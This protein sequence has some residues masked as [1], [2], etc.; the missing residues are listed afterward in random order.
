MSAPETAALDYDAEVQRVRRGSDPADTERNWRKLHVRGIYEEA[1]ESV[2]LLR[3]A[4]R[5]GDPIDSEK[6]CLELGDKLCYLV[7]A[8]QDRGS[9]FAE[10]WRTLLEL[11]VQPSA[12]ADDTC[13]DDLFGAVGGVASRFADER[14]GIDV[15]Q[16]MLY[17]LERCLWRLV[18]VAAYYGFTVED[19]Q[20]AN[21]AKLRARFPEGYTIAAALAKADEQKAGVQ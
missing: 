11:Y 5:K 10:L 16:G 2:S 9:S 20:R 13:V 12:P 8:A 4:E 6:L 19:L 18:L 15:R 3:K 7:L 1:G 14:R 17:A 21:I